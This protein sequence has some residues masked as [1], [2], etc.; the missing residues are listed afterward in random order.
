VSRHVQ[1]NADEFPFSKLFPNSS[2]YSPQIS[3]F[4]QSTFVL[5]SIQSFPICSSYS[6]VAQSGVPTPN[7]SL[8]V[9]SCQNITADGSTPN[10]TNQLSSLPR[11]STSKTVPASS[12][13]PMI[14]RSKSKHL[15]VFSP[16]ALISSAEPNSV[17]ETFL[18]SKWVDAMNDEYTALQR[19]KTWELVPFSSEMNLIDSKWIFR[20]KYNPDGS[21]LKH[22]ARLVVKGFLQ[23]PRIDF[24]KAFSPIIKAPTIRIL[25]SLA[26]SFG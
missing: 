25:F 13:H 6:R 19:N 9:E 2:L 3:S 10:C 5:H 11:S 23:N 4:G 22:K 26:V 15:V 20:V 18:D 8:P 12:I 14:T 21:I 1:F 24:A 16:H 17:Q 7:G